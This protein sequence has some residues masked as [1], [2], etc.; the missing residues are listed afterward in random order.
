MVNYFITNGANKWSA[1]IY[2]E[3]AEYKYI[4]MLKSDNDAS[5]LY[6]IRGS[7]EEHF[8]YFVENRLNYCD[9][10]WYGPNYAKKLISLRIYTPQG[11]QIITPNANI[12]ITPYS[13]MYAGV[14]YRANGTL[15]QQRAEANVPVTFIAPAETFNDTETA[16]YGASEISSLGDLAPLYCGSVNVSDATKLIE[17]K[18]GD[19]T[20]GYINTN[21]KDLSVGTNKLLK[22]LIYK[23]ARI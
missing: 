13:N 22:K 12:T 11:E 21:L 19:G 9:S 2:N 23:I 10:K 18:I 5:N 7:G 6:Q 15:Q 14:K 8:R 17:L 20:E 16:I 3:D 4:S 1:S